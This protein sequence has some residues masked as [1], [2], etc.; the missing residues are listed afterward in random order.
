MKKRNIINI[1][2]ILTVIALLAVGA[3]FVRIRPVADRVAVLSTAGMTCDRCG[4]TIENALRTK[5]GVAAVEIDVKGGRVIVAYDS[6]AT[7]PAAISSTVGCLGYRNSIA[8]CVSAEQYR[9]VAGRNPGVNG[10][11]GCGDC[12]NNIR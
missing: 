4:S 11:P 7:D 12:C 6:K 9:K 1:A 3:M 5:K 8:D 10:Q 2:L